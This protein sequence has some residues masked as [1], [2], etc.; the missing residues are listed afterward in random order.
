MRGINGS[1]AM[2]VQNPMRSCSSTIA[3]PEIGGQQVLSTVPKR[4][5]AGRIFG[6]IVMLFRTMA[7]LRLED[8]A[9]ERLPPPQVPCRFS[10]FEHCRLPRPDVWV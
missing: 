6:R 10:H 2:S 5:A 8:E 3:V 4:H 9:R 1:Q 7:V